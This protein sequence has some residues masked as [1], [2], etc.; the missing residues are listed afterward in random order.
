ML[1]RYIVVPYEKDVKLGKLRLRYEYTVFNAMVSLH[2]IPY[3]I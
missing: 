3:T 2:V 1:N